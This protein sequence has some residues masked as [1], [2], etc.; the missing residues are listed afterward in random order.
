VNT[1]HPI[2]LYDTYVAGIWDTKGSSRGGG[3]D[4]KDGGGSGSRGRG[5]NAAQFQRTIENG[6]G[7]CHAHATTTSKHFAYIAL[8][9]H[10]FICANVHNL[11]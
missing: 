5:P 10:A 6:M 3:G 11:F 2:F 4:G 8:Q 9:M 7:C 1:R